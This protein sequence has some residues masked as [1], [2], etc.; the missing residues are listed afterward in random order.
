MTFALGHVFKPVFD[1]LRPSKY[2]TVDYELSFSQIIDYS[3]DSSECFPQKLD[4]LADV[5]IYLQITCL[6]S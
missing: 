3:L 4:V 5:Y 2:L 6:V 1:G